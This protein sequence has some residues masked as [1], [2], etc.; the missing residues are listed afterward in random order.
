CYACFPERKDLSLEKIIETV[1][2][3]SGGNIDLTGGEPTVRD[4]LES[5]IAEIRQLGKKVQ[6]VTNGLKLSDPAY[7]K[8]LIDA[9]LDNVFFSFDS[10]KGSFYGSFKEGCT[11]KQAILDLKKR[12]LENLDKEKIPT[13]LAATIYPGLNDGEIKDLFVFALEK[14][15]FIYQ[16][17]LI[18]CIKPEYSNSSNIGGYFLSELVDIFSRQVGIKKE[19]LK[20]KF[21]KS[22]AGRRL[23]VE[24]KGLNIHFAGAHNIE[25]IDIEM[26]RSP[27]LYLCHDNTVCDLLVGF[28]RD[29]INYSDAAL[30]TFSV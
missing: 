1:K 8:R 28:A 19:T 22:R 6:I 26:Q 3:F 15:D 27:C 2:G 11:E 20:T 9:G 16:L 23:I 25:N 10:F 5:V 14:S 21:I 12:A 13:V 18:N 17:R 30:P 24:F 7:L 29:G 4:D